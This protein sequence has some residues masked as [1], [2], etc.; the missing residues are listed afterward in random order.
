MRKQ[1]DAVEKITF[2]TSSATPNT[3]ASNWHLYI[4]VP[5]SGRPYLRFKWMYTADDWLFIRAITL[6][7]DG[8]KTP[9]AAIGHSSVTDT[10]FFKQLAYSKK[11]IIRYEGDK[12]Y[13]DRV[14]SESEK[15]LSSRY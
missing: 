4:G 11:T 7:V 10:A 8:S 1:R 12:Y 6:N 3:I 9:T 13:K 2:Y 14:L 15:K 5:D